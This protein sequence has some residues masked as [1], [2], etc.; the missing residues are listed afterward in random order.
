MSV[1]MEGMRWVDVASEVRDGSNGNPER[2]YGAAVS[3]DAYA[4]S[5]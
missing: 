5:E 1:G 2:D 4:R 3:R